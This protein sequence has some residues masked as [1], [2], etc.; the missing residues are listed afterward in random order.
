M[1]K[2]DNKTIIED[3]FK[4][5]DSVN[6]EELEYFGKDPI[7]KAV[8]QEIIDQSKSSHKSRGIKAPVWFEYA[9]PAKKISAIATCVFILNIPLSIIGTIILFYL[10]VLLDGYI[11]SWKTMTLGHAVPIFT[12]I[13]PFLG[14][15]IFVIIAVLT[16]LT[17]VISLIVSKIRKE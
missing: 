11:F 3:E 16:I 14:I 2:R 13:L 15:C 10:G 4:G 17:A 1:E 8:V 9:G 7:K 6:D 5:I 12:V